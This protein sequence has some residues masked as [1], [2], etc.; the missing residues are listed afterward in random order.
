MQWQ[1]WFV[2]KLKNMHNKVFGKGY[3]LYDFDLLFG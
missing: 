1:Q 2:Q 3:V